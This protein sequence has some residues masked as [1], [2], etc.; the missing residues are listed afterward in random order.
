MEPEGL[1]GEWGVRPGRVSLERPRWNRGLNGAR[2]WPQAKVGGKGI[3]GEG[4]DAC[5]YPKAGKTGVLK[6]QQG[7]SRENRGRP[8]SGVWAHRR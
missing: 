6:A 7:G 1:G 8:G 3:S 2:G 4:V 5:R